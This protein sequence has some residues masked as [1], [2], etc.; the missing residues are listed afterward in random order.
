MVM[1]T[2][3]VAYASEQ[4]QVLIPVVITSGST[5]ADVITASGLLQQFPELDL[6]G[7]VVGIFSKRVKLHDVVQSGDRVEI[8]RPLKIDP[9]QARRERAQTNKR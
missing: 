1:I 3:E 6:Q 4:E 2:V 9:K 5:V 7:N 8:Y